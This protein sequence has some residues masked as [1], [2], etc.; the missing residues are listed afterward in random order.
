MRIHLG[1]RLLAVMGTA[2]LGLSLLSITA[3]AH[4][5]RNVDKYKLA[6][7]FI[8][9]PAIEGQK[10]GIDLR[11]SNV[12]DPA[13]AK[14]VIGLEKTLQVEITH[15][16]SKTTKTFAIRAIFND[17][18]HYT[19]DLIMTAPGQY[20]FRFFGT[21]EGVNVNET[22]T[23]GPGTFGDV[24]TSADLQFPQSF[25]QMRDRKSVV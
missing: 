1:T 19:N 17:A 18:G 25:P 7:G 16:P 11:V 23:S 20:K 22:F 3:L 15:V 12:S 2:L 21:I 14:P 24:E 5:S 8:T 6:V 10:N 13:A 9:E 4:E